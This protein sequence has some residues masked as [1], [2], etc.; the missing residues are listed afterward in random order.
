M[1]SFAIVRLAKSPDLRQK[2]G[3]AGKQRVLI[4]DYDWNQKIDHLLR[5]FIE[6]IE[7]APARV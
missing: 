7:A 4:G 1:A 3:Q 6:T 5:V 2:M